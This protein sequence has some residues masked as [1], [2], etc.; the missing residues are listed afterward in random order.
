MEFTVTY[1][2]VSYIWDFRKWFDFLRIAFVNESTFPRSRLITR[3]ISKV[4]EDMPGFPSRAKEAACSGFVGRS[5]NKIRKGQ[6]N[7]HSCLHESKCA[8]TAVPS[9]KGRHSISDWG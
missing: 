4:N 1:T 8:I 7:A 6:R 3:A 2:D 9:M 5:Q